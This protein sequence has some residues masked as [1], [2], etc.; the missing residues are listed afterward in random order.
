MG[1]G[2]HRG[3]PKSCTACHG[4]PFA[5]FRWGSVSRAGVRA[6]RERLAIHEQHE[7]RLMKQALDD[8]GD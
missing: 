2:D 3:H 1:D 6:L 8:I 5:S 7:E 4:N